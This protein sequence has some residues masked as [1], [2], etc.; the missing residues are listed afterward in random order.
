MGQNSGRSREVKP[1]DSLL[2]FH[3]LTTELK[4]AQFDIDNFYELIVLGELA[5]F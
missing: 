4:K 5:G 3:N 2:I 1:L